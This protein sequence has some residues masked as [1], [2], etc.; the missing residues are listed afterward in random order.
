MQLHLPTV[1]L[2]A[3]LLTA[4]ITLGTGLLAWRD[5]RDY[6]RHW[7]AALA[8]TFV[9]M[10]L[11]GL[12]GVAPDL[13]TVLLANLM[14]LGNLLFTI[15]GYQRLFGQPVPWRAMLLFSLGVFGAYGWF[16]Y[17]DD[18]YPVRVLLF[19]GTLVL[20]SAVSAVLLWRQRRRLG[21]TLLVL[22]IGAHLLQCAMGSLRFVLTLSDPGSGGTH[23]QAAGPV[24][25]AAIMLNSAAV[26]ALAFGFLALH[27]GHLLEELNQQA[28]TDALTGLANRRGFEPALQVE[29]QRHRRLGTPLTLLAIDIDHFK[30][31]ND[32][33]GHAAGDA[34]LRHLG[35]VLRQQLRPYDLS[36]RVGG[37]EFC[38]VQSGMGAEEAVQAAERLRTADLCFGRD[39][40]GQ[41]LQM[42]ISIGLATARTDDRD[43]AQLLARADAALYLAKAEGRNRVV[44][45]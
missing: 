17:V 11:F 27:A 44:Q 20:L 1:L 25:I 42:T 38:V 29:W 7:A 10:L 19:S 30:Q 31:I 6:L 26:M 40:Q 45:A 23:L 14:L 41:P 8:S 43:I 34:A 9:G 22:P 36:A 4:V 24:H 15:S 28:S 21:W 2:F 12:R 16:I 37:E 3:G 13:L 33:H 35:Q 18:S 39:A 32:R 5:R